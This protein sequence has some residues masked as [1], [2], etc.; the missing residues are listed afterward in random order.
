MTG[1]RASPEAESHDRE[2]EPAG[3]TGAIPGALHC[4]Y[5]D[6]LRAYRSTQ[7]LAIGPHARCILRRH[8][9]RFRKCLGLRKYVDDAER[10]LEQREHRIPEEITRDV[11]AAERD[12]IIIWRWGFEPFQSFFVPGPRH[13]RMQ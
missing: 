6:N 9:E 12:P 11:D 4:A 3:L 13:N 2:H 5:Q 1:L 7:L 10:C 8:I